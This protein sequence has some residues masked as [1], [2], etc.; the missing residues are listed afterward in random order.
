MFFNHVCYKYR[1]IC[2]LSSQTTI[3]SIKEKIINLL[4]F[5][6]EN[7]L[8][9]LLIQIIDGATIERLSNFIFHI[10]KCIFKQFIKVHEGLINDNKWLCGI[11][12]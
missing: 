3:T 10:L 1:R 5:S 6:V 12:F 11:L 9:V 4:V 7:V 8:Y 2:A